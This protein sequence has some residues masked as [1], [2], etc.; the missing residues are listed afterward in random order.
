MNNGKLDSKSQLGKNSV[1][2]ESDETFEIK[3]K[4][5]KSNSKE[6]SD[7]LHTGKHKYDT[8][9]HSNLYDQIRS[10]PTGGYS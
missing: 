1:I 8:A 3:S 2:Q 4:K 7:Y 6:K 5:E 9:V 10:I